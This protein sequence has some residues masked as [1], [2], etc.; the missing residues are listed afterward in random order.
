MSQQHFS[1]ICQCT[2]PELIITLS[3][4]TS[5][6]AAIVGDLGVTFQSLARFGKIAFDIILT[7]RY[8]ALMGVVFV[9]VVVVFLFF[10]AHSDKSEGASSAL[11]GI[12]YS[13]KGDF[14]VFVL[15]VSSSPTE[16]NF[17]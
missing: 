5:S 1:C 6:T 4:S 15:L 9:D 2:V 14:V 16:K 7:W 13:W 11:S 17:K 10:L 3:K 8:I 12:V